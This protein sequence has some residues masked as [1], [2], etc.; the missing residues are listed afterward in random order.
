MEDRTLT[1]SERAELQNW[2]M[3]VLE[4]DAHR[5]LRYQLSLSRE[6]KEHVLVTGGRGNGKTTAITRLLSEIDR[7][8]VQRVIA[9]AEYQPKQ[10][11]YMVASKAEGR[12]T[13]LLDLERALFGGS[14]RNRWVTAHALVENLAEEFQTRSIT[15]LCVD[16]AQMVSPDNLDLLR[17]VPDACAQRG[18]PLGLVLV[19]SEELRESLLEIQQMGQRFSTEIRF[20]RLT[21]SQ[22]TTNLPGFHPHLRRL[23]ET[24]EPVEWKALEQSVVTAVA[25]SFRRLGVLLMN[26]NAL[27]LEKNL[28]ISP[29]IIHAAIHKLASEA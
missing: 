27:A 19:G 7:E 10:T 28:P 8:E 6:G 16:E 3:P 17:Q 2:A 1:E 25:G 29:A 9:D 11:M 18:H 13:V 20:P 24:L 15:L 14:T 22:V 12:K 23:G 4:L 5:E 26:I 21:R